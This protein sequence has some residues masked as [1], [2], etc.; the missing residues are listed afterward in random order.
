VMNAR[1]RKIQGDGYWMS[2]WRRASEAVLDQSPKG[3][4]AQYLGQIED[5]RERGEDETCRVP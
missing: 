4:A 3:L 5:R 2:V 1:I